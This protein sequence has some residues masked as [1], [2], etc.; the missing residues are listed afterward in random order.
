MGL[1]DDVRRHCAEV[2]TGAR[3][4]RIDLEAAEGIEAGPPPSLDPATH[5]LEG[6][7]EE[8]ATF[9]LT[10]DAINFGSGWFPTLRKPAGRSGYFTVASA[11]AARFRAA[12]PWSPG[13]LLELDAEAVARVLGQEP[14]HE[15][16]ALYAQALNDLGAFL[17]DHRDVVAHG[18]VGEQRLDLALLALPHVALS[19][20]QPVAEDLPQFGVGLVALVEVVGA[21]GKHVLHHVRVEEEGGLAVVLA[22]GTGK[23][24]HVAE[25]EHGTVRRAE[26]VLLQFEQR[27]DHREPLGP[28]G[29]VPVRRCD[30]RDPGLH[31]HI[32]LL[33]V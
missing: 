5:Y 6:E 21:G 1:C 23:A 14:D 4:I 17:G 15:L 30:L 26:Q 29:H 19:R 27:P 31:G 16:M 25:L 2:A 13:E 11:L 12:G 33:G 7:P 3:S 18:L 28:R 20:Q 22:R 10:L 9:L 24:H 32:G 8:V